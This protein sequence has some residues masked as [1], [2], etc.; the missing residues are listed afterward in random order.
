MTSRANNSHRTDFWLILSDE[1]GR[2][3]VMGDEASLAV[4]SGEGEAELF[5]RWGMAGDGWKVRRAA[6]GELA[7]LLDGGRSEAGSILLDPSPE[8]FAQRMTALVRVRKDRF[9]ENILKRSGLGP[10]CLA[11]S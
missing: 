5:L 10:P 1:D 6:S 2:M 7:S 3:L 8:M 11:V 9:V 4:F